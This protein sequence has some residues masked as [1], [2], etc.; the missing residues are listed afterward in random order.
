MAS[1]PRL[2]RNWQTHNTSTSWAVVTT[3]SIRQMGSLSSLMLSVFPQVVQGHRRYSP[4][5]WERTLD[6]VIGDIRIFDQALT[7]KQI[8]ELHNQAR[9]L[10]PPDLSELSTTGRLLPRWSD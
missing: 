5:T 3:R 2:L 7:A 6:G 9:S 4:H 8:E 1:L 10:S